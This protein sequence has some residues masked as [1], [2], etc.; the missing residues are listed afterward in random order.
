MIQSRLI[1]SK[2]VFFEKQGKIIEML[3]KKKRIVFPIKANRI[4]YKKYVAS[5]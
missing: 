5:F 2:I 4:L 3:Y 1:S